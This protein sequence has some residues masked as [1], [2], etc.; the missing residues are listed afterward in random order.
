VR[1]QVQT[2]ANGLCQG[3]EDLTEEEDSSTLFVIPA[4][5][6]IQGLSVG[7]H[8]RFRR[9]DYDQRLSAIICVRILLRALLSL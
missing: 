6:G 1:P 9:K 8:S 4:K 7:L 2:S 5:G 3:A